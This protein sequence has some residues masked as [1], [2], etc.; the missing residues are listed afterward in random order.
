MI[1]ARS[2]IKSFGKQSVLAGVSF[3]IEAGQS[4]VVLG[5][6]GSGKSVL[7]KHLVGLMEPDSGEVL[8]GGQ[9]LNGM[10]ERQLL[11]VRRK[12]G[13]LFQGAALFDSLSVGENI[14]FAMRRE[15]KL[16]VDEINRRIAEMLE[17]VDLPGIQNKKP[18]ELSGGMKKRVGLARAI[19]HRPEVLLYD[20][21]TTGLDPVGSDSIDQL[22]ER[23]CEQLKVTSIIVTH[24][25]RTARRLGRRILLL[26]DGKIF[27]D[28]P[29]SV[30]FESK[31]PYVHNFV[32]GIANPKEVGLL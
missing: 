1:E 21:P 8:V 29:A 14:G 7:L 16:T 12:F 15:R 19:A 9:P 18:S 28:S 10:T 25:M 32:N 6:S 23:V 4:V 27:L 31:D 13:M 3:V 2:I 20:E 22:M 17:L 5:R 11:E 24:D 30:V 26:R